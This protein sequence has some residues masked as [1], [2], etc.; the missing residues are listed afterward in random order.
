MYLMHHPYALDATLTAQTVHELAHRQEII[1]AL[2]RFA[3]GRDLKDED[4][5]ASAF[6]D[7]AEFDFRPVGER[8]GLEFPLMHG[9]DKIAAIVLDPEVR[10]D[11]SHTVTN[12]RVRILED[13]AQLTALVEAQ[14]LPSADHS[15]HLLL[16][17]VY[18]VDLVRERQR[19]LMSRVRIENLWY[20]G[21]PAV[22]TGR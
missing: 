3:I 11:T 18:D 16:K 14:H 19:W 21:D 22:I 4:L 9:R 7:D 10:L 5:F 8:I 20:T 12:C 17:N 1:D 6:T 13:T 15:R 2:Y